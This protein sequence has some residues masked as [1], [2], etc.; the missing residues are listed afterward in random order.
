MLLPTS[1]WKKLFSIALKRERKIYKKLSQFLL[2]TVD[3]EQQE[4]L[5]FTSLK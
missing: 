1:P 3:L 2:Q 5:N 4:V